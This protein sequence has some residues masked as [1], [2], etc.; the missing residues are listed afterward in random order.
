VTAGLV[1]GGRSSGAAAAD[2]P[3]DAEE[4]PRRRRELGKLLYLEEAP[5]VHGLTAN[6]RAWRE[7]ITFRRKL[8]KKRTQTKN[9]IRALLR[10]LGIQA[11]AL[12]LR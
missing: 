1:G 5:T 8:V 10:S 12:P 3:V 2:F 6:V 9:G 7:L 11:P 4:R